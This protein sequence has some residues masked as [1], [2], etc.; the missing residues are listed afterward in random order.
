MNE[1]P[2]PFSPSLAAPSPAGILALDFYNELMNHTFL[3]PIPS[4]IP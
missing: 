2:S 1:C 4:H 3:D